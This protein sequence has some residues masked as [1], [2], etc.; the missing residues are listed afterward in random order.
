MKYI[1]QKWKFRLAASL[2]TFGAVTAARA[3]IITIG[4]GQDDWMSFNPISYGYFFESTSTV[5]TQL[6]YSAAQIKAA[7]VAG[8][9]LLDSIAFDVSEAPAGALTNF[10]VK[11]KNSAFNSLDS[12]VA[13]NLT[14]V[15]SLPSH[16]ADSGWS[17]IKFQTP[18]YW[19]GVDNILFD[20]CA[21]PTKA[22]AL[23]GKIRMTFLSDYDPSTWFYKTGTK[24]LCGN[25]TDGYG[26]AATANLKMSFRAASA[27]TG[28][29]VTG[30]IAPSG[31]LTSC[32][33]LP[34]YLELVNAPQANV[35][36]QWQNSVEGG[37]WTNVP[38]QGNGT[39]YTVKV[40]SNARYIEYRAQMTCAA[41]GQTSTSNVMRINRTD[42]PT[43]AKLPYS[44]DFESWRSKCATSD[45]PDTCWSALPP[46]GISSWRREDEG[47]TADWKEDVDPY[48]YYPLSS[49]GSHSARFQ[50]SKA[51][52]N[53]SL[54]LHLNCE[55][56]GANELRFDYY[57]KTSEGLSFLYVLMSKD[58]GATFDTL[59]SLD[60]QGVKSAAWHTMVIPF[61]SVSPT[62]II[63]FEGHSIGYQ[64]GDFDMGI[65][66]L[67]IY[68]ACKE[69]PVAGVIDSLSACKGEGVQLSLSGTSKNGGQEWLWQKTTDGIGWVDVQGGN[70]EHPA[71]SIDEDTWFRCI[72]TCTASGMSDTS[73]PRLVTITPYYKC[74]CA[75]GSTVP[76]TNINLGNIKISSQPGAKILLDNGNPLPPTSN[77]EARKHYSDFTDLA[78]AQLYRD[79][80]YRI[81]LTFFTENGKNVWPMM[82]ESQ[83]VVYID[84]NKNGTF[85]QSERIFYGVKEMDIFVDSFDFKV[86]KDAQLGITGMRIV[87]ND[88]TWDSAA[89]TACGSY[90]YGETEDYLVRISNAPCTGIEETGMLAATDTSLCPGYPF[91]LVHSGADSAAGLIETIWQRSDDGNTWSDITGTEDQTSLKSEFDASVY[92]RIKFTCGANNV[93]FYGDSLHIEEND[94]CYCVSYATGGFSGFADSSD[95]GSF[96]LGT[97][98]LP[99]SG[100]HLNNALATEKYSN[101]THLPADV[102]YVDSNY[103]F[104]MDHILL[105]N[106]HSDA[107]I[108]LFIDY[109]GNGTFDIPQERVYSGISTKTTWH[110]VEN[111]TVPSDAVLDKETGM[112][113]II[114][115]DTSANIPSDEACGT[116]VSG[117]T[118]DFKVMF[119]KGQKVGVQDQERMN[120]ALSVY[121]NPAT[122]K[123]NLE[124]S[125]FAGRAAAIRI[126]NVEGRVMEEQSLG[127]WNGQLRK[128]LDL[129][130]YA[131]GVYFISFE[132]DG[133]TV[134]K[135]VIIQ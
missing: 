101:Y 74:Y 45:V 96:K 99:L 107:K 121:P 13:T 63:R 41:S 43:Y 114:N 66:N 84:Y 73:A 9:G 48:Y 50:S 33:N 98:N 26:A 77:L 8:P 126:T 22:K 17:W 11:A 92:Y 34:V 60:A 116:Y 78:P 106:E 113:M 70:V 88:E 124:C 56:Q 80:N 103:S 40:Q 2:L 16:K 61:T 55:D 100:G 120:L 28:M 109:N 53:G 65:D 89:I 105:R 69:K 57:N 23:T 49:T 51:S 38:G 72:V 104:T 59:S 118:I 6:L 115:N 119:R 58:D 31:A 42:N 68:P 14:T 3:Q 52:K 46:T 135:K 39:A 102:L 90:G 4:S 85:E 131:K 97:I 125:G 95:I 67:H 24:P 30:V 32:A 27:C 25:Y 129:S 64:S 71:T 111:I 128:T 122:G 29:P 93:S 82:P 132:S 83:S 47:A 81:N 87:T 130:A 5:H 7:G 123:V 108:T 15:T 110:K 10:T 112:R 79:S 21:D 94:L 18:F 20:F 91:T 37:A 134:N 44:Q 62:T 35:K 76:S 75:S 19:N 133:Q 117:H 127:K 36:I 12:F 86:P 1:L 54:N